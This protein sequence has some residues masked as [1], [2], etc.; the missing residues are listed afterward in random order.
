M[1]EPVA[2]LSTAT[3]PLRHLEDIPPGVS[4]QPTLCFTVLLF[5]LSFRVLLRPKA[6]LLMPSLSM[7]VSSDTGQ[8]KDAEEEQNV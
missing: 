2:P 1:N 5:Q 3:R 4:A 8:D 6:W 7:S